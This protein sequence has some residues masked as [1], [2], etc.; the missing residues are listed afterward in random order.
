[1]NANSTSVACDCT[2][3]PAGVKSFPYIVVNPAFLPDACQASATGE[4]WSSAS[5][6]DVS[7]ITAFLQQQPGP[8]LVPPSQVGPDKK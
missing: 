2:V 1:M 7:Q 4:V 8:R 5:P 6:D 3:P